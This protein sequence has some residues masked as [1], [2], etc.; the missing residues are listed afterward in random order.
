MT[1][2]T[3]VMDELHITVSAPS[4]LRP[5]EFRSIRRALNRP[6]FRSALND[7]V[8]AVFQR[9]PSLAKVRVTISR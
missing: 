4:N 6:G 7:A 8:N 3:V 2:K 1:R 5:A 9:Y